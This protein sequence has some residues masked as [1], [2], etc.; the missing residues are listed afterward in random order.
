M[1]KKTAKVRNHKAWILCKAWKAWMLLGRDRLNQHGIYSVS[2]LAFHGLAAG[3]GIAQA[4]RFMYISKDN[5]QNKSFDL[6][7]FF[8]RPPHYLFSKMYTSG[9]FR[10]N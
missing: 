6:K 8:L 5:I 7:I 9:L 3:I 2:S 1:Q 10:S 4:L